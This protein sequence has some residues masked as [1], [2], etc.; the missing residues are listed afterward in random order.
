MSADTPIED[1]QSLLNDDS[2]LS[3]RVREAIRYRIL[4]KQVVKATLAALHAKLLDLKDS[5]ESHLL[6]DLGFKKKDKG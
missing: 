3:P 5:T 1:D 2:R 4:R 6:D